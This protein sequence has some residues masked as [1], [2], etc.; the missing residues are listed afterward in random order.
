MRMGFEDK[1]VI[2]TV[3][4]GDRNT[5]RVTEPDRAVEGRRQ[6]TVQG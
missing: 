6:A 3:K 1:H 2:M 4:C 5:I